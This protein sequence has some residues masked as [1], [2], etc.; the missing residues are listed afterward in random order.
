MQPRWDAEALE[1]PH[2]PPVRVLPLAAKAQDEV[3]RVVLL[4]LPQDVART[5]PAADPED[6]RLGEIRAAMGEDVGERSGLPI[7]VR[8]A[9]V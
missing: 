7:R 6:H 1:H 8:R 3:R 5:E 4:E 9:V 2:R